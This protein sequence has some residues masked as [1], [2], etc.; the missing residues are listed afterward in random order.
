MARNRGVAME[1][2]EVTEFVEAQ[3]TLTLATIGRDGRPHLVAMWF[4]RD[5]DELLMWAYGASQKIRNIERDSRVTVH[6]EQ[7]HAYDEL[8]GVSL[9]ARAE[10]LRDPA[11]VLAVGRRVHRRYRGGEPSDAPEE[12]RDQARKR[13][14]LRLRIEGIH[15]WDHRKLV[16]R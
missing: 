10:I 14:A 12:P 9:D 1:P 2:E 11:D 6:A 5:G 13:V 8:R 4:A 15:S 7:G 3:R 16:P